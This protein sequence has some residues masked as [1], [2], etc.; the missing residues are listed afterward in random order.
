MPPTRVEAWGFLRAVT[1]LDRYLNGSVYKQAPP[2]PSLPRLLSVMVHSWTLLLCLAGFIL[3]GQW[4]GC[5]PC[6]TL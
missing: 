4:L 5:A 2:P 6:Q 1:H 3:M